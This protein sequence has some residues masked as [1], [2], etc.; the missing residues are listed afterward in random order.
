MNM[1]R[2]LNDD[3]G[4]MNLRSRDFKLRLLD[5]KAIIQSRLK[6]QLI[7]M[8]IPS[9]ILVIGGFV[10]LC[11]F[12]GGVLWGGCVVWCVCGGVG[13]WVYGVGGGAV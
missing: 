1:V 13:G 12:G 7:N 2:Y 4:L 11:W 8:L 5:R 9:A 10:W 6:W 3:E